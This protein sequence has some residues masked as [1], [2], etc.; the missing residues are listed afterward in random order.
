[1]ANVKQARKWLVTINNPV[2]H[3]F[4]HERIKEVLDGMA[5]LVYWCMA[6]EKGSCHHTHIYVHAKN[7]KTFE[8]MKNAFPPADLRACNGTSRD[9]YEYITKTGKKID[10]DKAE[11]RLDGTFEEWGELPDE[12]PG[13]RVDLSELVDDI[14]DGMT[15]VELIEKNP[16]NANKLDMINKVRQTIRY[17]KYKTLFREMIGFYIYGS[18]GVGKTRMVLD[19]QVGMVKHDKRDIYRVCKYTHPFDAYQGE[20]VIVF[21]EFRSSLQVGDMLN[22]LDGHAMVLPARYGDKQACYSTF[23]IVSNEPLRDQYNNIQQE[24]PETWAAFLRRIKYLLRFEQNEN[25][26]LVIVSEDIEEHMTGAKAPGWDK[27]TK[28]PAQATFR[29]LPDDNG[30]LPF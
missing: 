21:D 14:K 5:S 20:S 3:G 4:P 7:P 6:D 24:H 26:E 18:T 2:E 23:Y 9:N 25:G 11:T 16:N 29:E 8:V 1:M 22:Y 19:G 27:P 10:T 30:E 15:D 13:R 12:R 17:D 28:Q